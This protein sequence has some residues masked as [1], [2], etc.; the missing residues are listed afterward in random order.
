MRKLRVRGISRESRITIFERTA[1]TRVRPFDIDNKNIRRLCEMSKNEAIAIF[2]GY[3]IKQTGIENGQLSVTFSF[4]PTGPVHSETFF[5]D[6]YAAFM[7][8]LSAAVLR[9][10][11]EEGYAPVYRK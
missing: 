2:A 1:L 9:F 10:N 11:G 6:K 8:E 3:E 7:R 4:E 5:A